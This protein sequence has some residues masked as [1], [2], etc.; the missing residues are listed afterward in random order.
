MVVEATWKAGRMLQWWQDQGFHSQAPHTK[1]PAHMLPGTFLLHRS[2]LF[3]T[4]TACKGSQKHWSGSSRNTASHIFMQGHNLKCAGTP[5]ES[6]IIRTQ[7]VTLSDLLKDYQRDCRQIT[8]LSFMFK[9]GKTNWLFQ[10]HSG[11]S[12]VFQNAII[13]YGRNGV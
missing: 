1:G 4:T 2:S 13:L 3:C 9:E 6:W 11:S 12:Q 7:K 5:A 10:N 8:M